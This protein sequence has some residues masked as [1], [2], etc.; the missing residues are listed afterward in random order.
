M[1]ET[2][3]LLSELYDGQSAV[4]CEIKTKGAMRARLLD[5]GLI[6]GTKVQ[7]LLHAP[8]GSPIAYNIRGA[9]IALRR[10]DA[11]KISVGTAKWD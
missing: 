5:L 3:G 7:C 2:C 10:K 8:S 4:V 11:A 6:P 9:E 1:D